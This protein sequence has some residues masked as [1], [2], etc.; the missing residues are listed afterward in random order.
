MGVNGPT[1]RF[2]RSALL[3][4]GSCPPALAFL[5]PQRLPWELPGWGGLMHPPGP[6]FQ[7]LSSHI[8]SDQK[9]VTMKSADFL[10]NWSEKPG[11]QS[12]EALPA[13]EWD[14]S[15]SSSV[16]V[17]VRMCSGSTLKATHGPFTQLR[18]HH[19]LSGSATGC[20]NQL[21]GVQ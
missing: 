2:H 19:T 18:R 9:Q 4:P 6:A 14:S 11:G 13:L 21:T 10:E 20:K 16:T 1:W 7:T 17:A 8:N 5:L 15:H 3:L 12:V